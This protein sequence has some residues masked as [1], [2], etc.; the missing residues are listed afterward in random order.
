MSRHPGEN[1]G[2]DIFKRLKSLDS[3]QKHAG[4]TEGWEWLINV[5]VRIGFSLTRMMVDGVLNT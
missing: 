3:G 1:R 5:L 2:P 4:M